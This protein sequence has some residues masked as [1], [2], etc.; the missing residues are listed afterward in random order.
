[1]AGRSAA[2]R[3]FLGAGLAAVDLGELTLGVQDL[4]AGLTA[5][6]FGSLLRSPDLPGCLAMI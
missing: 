3:S 2:A 5:D 4:G 1:M 6:V